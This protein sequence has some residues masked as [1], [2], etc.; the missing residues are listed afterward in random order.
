MDPPVDVDKLSPAARKILDPAS[1]APMRQMAAKGVAPGLKP[2]DALAVMAILSESTDQAIASAA[3][4]TLDKLPAPVLNGALASDLPP[5]VLALVAPRYAQNATVMERILGH[6]ALMPETVAAV[7]AAASEAVA[8][9]VATNEELL[10]AHPLIIEK[11]YMNEATRMSTADRIL[12]LAVRNKVELKG[13]PAYKEAAAAIG[14]ELLAE[15]TPE[16]NPDDVLFRET[17]AIAREASVD[18]T[19]EDTHH[20]DEETGV[21]V[22]DDRFLP[23][24][25]RL[26]QMTNSQKIRRAMLGT[27]AE[28]LL[29]VRDSN[30]LVAQSAIKSPSIQESEVVRMSASRNVSEDVLRTIAMDREWTRSHQI[31]VN[32]V[33]NPRTPFA[34]AAKLISHLREHELKALARSKNVTGAVSTAARQ[35]LSRRNVE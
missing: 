34:F 2:G 11:L 22:V 31:K 13:I 32:L 21:E 26:A 24:H 1:P 35:Q 10:L 18:P 29:L 27:A 20:L 15:R 33:Q 14:Q 3:K 8:E 25:A 16:P 12:E 6:P 4:A 23:L 9:L 7:A 30:R 17:V 28:R 19:V 5:G